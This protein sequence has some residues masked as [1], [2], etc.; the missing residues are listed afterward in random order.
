MQN[1]VF[2]LFSEDNTLDNYETEKCGAMKEELEGIQIESMPIKV[3]KAVDNID[4]DST[5]STTNSGHNAEVVRTAAS[6]VNTHSHNI[7]MSASGNSLVNAINN[8]HWN[9]H[10]YNI[11]EL[12]REV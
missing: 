12:K 2:P 3:E 11:K 9:N 8:T 1:R 10:A 6:N 4:A 7:T 5:A